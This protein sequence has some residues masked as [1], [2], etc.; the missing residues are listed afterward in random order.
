M[1]AEEA[2]G[3]EVEGAGGSSPFDPSRRAFGKGGEYMIQVDLS[4]C[5]GCGACVDVCP[6]GAIYIVDGHAEVDETLCNLCEACISACPKE[7][8]SSVPEV[9]S[10]PEADR[11]PQ[12]QPDKVIQLPPVRTEV[13]PWHQKVLPAVGV[14][15]SYA[16]RE[17][18]PRVVDSLVSALGPQDASENG[19]KAGGQGA[20]GGRR[21]RR[22]RRGKS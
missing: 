8:L 17:I 12:V 1:A 22:R 19:Q 4:R 5:T 2:A 3:S 21:A 11:L 16:G 6:M 14:V 10:T 9:V 13:T 15:V 20:G 18:L 7:A